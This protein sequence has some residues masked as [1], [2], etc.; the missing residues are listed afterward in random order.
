MIETEKVLPQKVRMAV[1]LVVL[2]EEPG[3][4]RDQA[5]VKAYFGDRAKDIEHIHVHNF[6]VPIDKEGPNP[7]R[8]EIE[9]IETNHEPGCGCALCDTIKAMEE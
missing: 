5:L 4:W 3:F 1:A 8:V 7:V 2:T 9:E 6:G